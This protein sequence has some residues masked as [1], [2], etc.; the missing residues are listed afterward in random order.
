[1]KLLATT[2]FVAFAHHAAV[3]AQEPAIDHARLLTAIQQVEGYAWSHPGGAYAIRLATWRQHT[4]LPYRYACIK[5]Y[6]DAWAVKHFGWLTRSLLADGYAVTPYSL[7]M[8]WR[9][10]LE[11]GK[12]RIG[13][14]GF[15]Y[16]HRA[17]NL[18]HVR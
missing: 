18:Y 10:G 8:C 3:H 6:A 11:G 17:A 1:M 5:E 7:A 16:G 2:T 12:V 14:P 4:H 9:Y 13:R 15:D